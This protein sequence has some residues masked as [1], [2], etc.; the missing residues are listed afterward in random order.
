MRAG[1]TIL[2]VAYPFAPVGPDAVGGAEQILTRLDHALTKAG[3][4]SFVLGSE[5]S[6]VHGT[7]IEVALPRGPLD[8][9]VRSA[10]HER[11]TAHLNA[12]V[13]RHRPD[14]VHCHGVDFYEYLPSPGVPVLVTLHLPFSYYHTDLTLIRRSHTYFHCVSDAQLASFPGLEGMLPPIPNGVPLTVKE[15]CRARDNFVL[16]LSRIAP[17]KNVHAALDAAKLANVPLLL[18]GEV[19]PYREHETYFEEEVKPR[20]DSQRRF[21]GALEEARKFDL[22]R[23]AR[24]LLQPSLAPETSSLVAMEALAS[25]TPVVTYPSGALATIVK[26]GYTGFVVHDVGGMAEAIHRADQI[27]P[28]VCLAE[29]ASRFGLDQMVQRYFSAYERVIR[30]AEAVGRVLP[31][32]R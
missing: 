32:K 28:N 21:L 5:R 1:S 13:T 14:L 19:Y 18:G 23:R 7:L 11:Y 31:G 15:P 9:R 17:E 4:R 24:C 26:D 2:S 3:H 27:N 8:D 30:P 16:C 6:R 10:H 20:L 12:A 25:G 29:A 22:L